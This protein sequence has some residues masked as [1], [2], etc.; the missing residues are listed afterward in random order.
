MRKIAFATTLIAIVLL[1]W[2][3]SQQAAVSA[4]AKEPLHMA[5]I[6]RHATGASQENRDLAASFVGLMST[7]REGQRIGFITAGDEAA[8]G[9]SVS[10]T[11]E[12]RSDYREILARL[13]DPAPAPVTDLSASLAYAHELMKFQGADEGSTLYVVSG[14]ELEGE[15]PAES[16]SLEHLISEFNAEGWQ[17]VSIALPGSSS[18]AEGFMSAVSDGTGSDRFPL[19]TPNELKVIADSILSQDARGTLFEIGNDDLA[20]DD[21]FTSTLNIAPSTTTASLVFFKEGPTGSLS[22]LNPSGDEAD[23]ALSDVIETPYMVVWLLVDPAPGK[24]TVEARGMEGFIS[25]WHYP[26]H[27]LNIDFV[28]FDSVPFD[29]R[30]DLVAF[31]SDGARRVAASD[32]EMRAMVIDP[33]GKT[34]SHV[35]NDNGELGDAVSGD[36]YYSTTLPQLGAAGEYQVELELYWPQY[37]HSISTRKVVTAQAFPSINVDWTA[38]EGLTPGERV[39]IGAAV[40]NIDGQPYAIPIDR[41]SAGAASEHGGV[42]E[43]VPQKLLNAGHAS[44][45]DIMFT[46]AQEERHTL[47]LRLDMEYAS[48]DYSFTTDSKVLSSVIPPAPPAVAPQPPPA[49]PVA[50]QP[51]AAPPPPPA[52][53]VAPAPPMVAP[54]ANDG[55]GMPA[56]AIYGLAAL[57]GALIIAGA[58]YIVY[59][60]TRPNPYGYLHDDEGNLLVNLSTLPRSAFT[61]VMSKNLVRGDELGIAELRG[62][63]F[64]FGKGQVDI[65]SEQTEPSIRINNKPLIDGQQTRAGNVSWIGTQGKLFSLQL[66]APMASPEPVAAPKYDDG[67]MG[68]EPAVAPSVGDD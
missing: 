38:T 29:Q 13:S 44:A 4:D 22:L 43:L 27:T 65:R 17:I 16:T 21:V 3:A 26:K 42:V 56:I 52:A 9:P 60:V 67:M 45:F 7:F 40:V 25:A 24:W 46:P 48:R 23:R 30:F 68:E 6:D 10:G 34:S 5:L 39:K 11:V 35:L 66:T 19:G 49:A 14:G 28:S 15:A 54:T 59:G 41:I 64:F 63:S 47:V 2:T 36:T 55:G 8:I 32:I 12:H 31:I 20:A 18:Y 50:P 51:A 61:L 62:L 1:S 57:A 53:P 33:D 37:E 58:I